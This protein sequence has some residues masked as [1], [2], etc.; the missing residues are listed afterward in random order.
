MPRVVN[1]LLAVLFLF[2]AVVQYN[3]PDPLPWMAIYLA[4]AL[5]CVLALAGR[6]PW[7]WAAVIAVIALAWALTLV[8]RAL[9]NVRIVEL[10]AAWEMKSERIEEAREMYGLL[11]IFISM[12]MLA[13]SSR[14]NAKV[15]RA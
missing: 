3:D 6:L 12:A 7:W 8:P 10:F 4:A 11:L 5:A 2:G 14:R 1:S 15:S 9:P 13:V